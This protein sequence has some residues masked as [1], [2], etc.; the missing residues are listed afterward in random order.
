MG[1]KSDDWLMIRLYMKWTSQ[2]N[3][4]SNKKSGAYSFLKTYILYHKF[5]MRYC[6]VVFCC[7][8]FVVDDSCW[9][10]YYFVVFCFAVN[11]VVASCWCSLVKS[12]QFL[13]PFCCCCSFSFFFFAF[14]FRVV[15]VI[16]EREGCC[17][18]QQKSLRCYK[19]IELFDIQ[20]WFFWPKAR[21]KL[22]ADQGR[23]KFYFRRIEHNV[24]D[25]FNNLY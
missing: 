8:Y 5:K 23:E 14:F 24:F 6:F 13:I 25:G 22:K 2:W 16:V 21:Q 3:S 12:S 7:W 9:S 19:T 1:C 20:L 4:K 11:D 18:V 15:V 17:V 10:W